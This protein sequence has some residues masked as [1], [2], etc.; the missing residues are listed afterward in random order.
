MLQ[1]NILHTNDDVIHYEKQNLSFIVNYEL[2]RIASKVA[3]CKE[4]L[5]RGQNKFPQCYFY[6]IGLW[7]LLS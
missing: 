6:I 2:D 4:F 1:E 7:A 5:T 3:K